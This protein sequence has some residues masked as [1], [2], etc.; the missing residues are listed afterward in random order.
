MARALRIERAGGRYHVT[1]RRWQEVARYVQLNPVR[2]ARLKLD[3]SGRAASHAG[4]ACGPGA[5]L[6]AERHGDWGRDAALWLGRRTAR[7]PLAEL[8]KSTDGLDYAV[9]SKALAPFGRRLEAD[10]RLRE[11]IAAIRDRLS[12]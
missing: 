10:P 7:F 12:K 4:V 5:E 8:G 2:V 1:A 6:V 3:K 9:V 11:D